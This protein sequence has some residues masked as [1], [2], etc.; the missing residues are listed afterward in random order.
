MSVK[1]ILY[2]GMIEGPYGDQTPS[3]VVG[4]RLTAENN[5]HAIWVGLRI[6]DEAEQASYTDWEFNA[7]LPDAT[8][9]E[10][11]ELCV[12]HVLALRKRHKE[13]ESNR[14]PHGI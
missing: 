12:R 3:Q 8:T 11:M 4:Y 6:L 5:G 9:F 2:Q 14:P 13:Q 7:F 1:H 10:A